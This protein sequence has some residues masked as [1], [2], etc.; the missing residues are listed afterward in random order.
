MQQQSRR[1][2]VPER[3]LRS[4]L[5]SLGLRFRKH[6]RVVPGL[7]REVDVVF[8]SRRVA[9]FVDGCFW[10][11]CPEHA[12]PSKS[13]AD[14]WSAKIA[15]TRARDSETDTIL[16]NEGWLVIRVWE[17]EDPG[18]AAQCIAGLVAQRPVIRTAKPLQ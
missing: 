14:W 16:R 12:R 6:L 17:H 10:H 9:V 11:G 5:F 4:S 15:R 3:L 7:R 13:N 8:Q 1:D 18:F 2:T